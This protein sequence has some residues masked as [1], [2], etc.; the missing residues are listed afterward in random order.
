MDYRYS[1]VIVIVLGGC[2]LLVPAIVSL[3]IHQSIPLT[4]PM[5]DTCLHWGMIPF[6]QSLNLFNLFILSL[7]QPPQLSPTFT[8]LKGKT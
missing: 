1:I 8:G 3:A 4:D 6:L 5:L 7:L 2:L